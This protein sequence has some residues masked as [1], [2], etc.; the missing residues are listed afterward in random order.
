MDVNE[1]KL[2]DARDE[3]RVNR[4]LVAQPLDELPHEPGHLGRW[5][6]RIDDLACLTVG[7]EV[8]N[9]A[10]LTG[11]CTLS[12][13]ALDQPLVDLAE[14][15]FADRRAAREVLADEIERGAVVQKLAHVVRVG[16]THL[17]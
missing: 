2:R 16:T 3:N 17:V 1:L 6:R 4:L 5:G 14:K 11:L 9:G 15:T 8:L 7:D 10:P 12:A 13:H